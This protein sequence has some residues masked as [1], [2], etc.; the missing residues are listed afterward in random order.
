M[1]LSATVSLI[2][3]YN[4]LESMKVNGQYRQGLYIQVFGV[5]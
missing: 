3:M 1:V 4:I 5:N 2:Q